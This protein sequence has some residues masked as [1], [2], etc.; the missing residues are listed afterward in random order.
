[1]ISYGVFILIAAMLAPRRAGANDAPIA[2]EDQN[3]CK[4]T[5]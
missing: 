4:R 3:D 2:V 5:Q 1:M